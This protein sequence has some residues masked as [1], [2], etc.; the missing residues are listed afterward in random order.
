MKLK[1]KNAK[2]KIKLKSKKLSINKYSIFKNLRFVSQWYGWK[3][4]GTLEDPYVLDSAEKIPLSL[5]FTSCNSHIYIKNQYLTNLRLYHCQNITIDNCYI[6]NFIIQRCQNIT[7][8][9]NLIL[10]IISLLSTANT[11]ENN[12]ILKGSHERLLNNYYDKI[13]SIFIYSGMIFGMILAL[14]CV[15]DIFHS[16]YLSR[17]ISNLVLTLLAF[18]IISYYFAVLLR[19]KK[20]PPNIFADSKCV[21][22]G[23]LVRLFNLEFKT[24]IRS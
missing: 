6:C 8:K 13:A 12:Q 2:L 3:G 7:V 24:A 17:S 23:P 9:N 20:L 4:A 14:M 5:T 21:T 1:L 16:H 10:K 15:Y 19:M 18:G 11:F 22:L